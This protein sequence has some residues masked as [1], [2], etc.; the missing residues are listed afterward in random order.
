MTCESRRRRGDLNPFLAVDPEICYFSAMSRAVQRGKTC[1]VYGLA[2]FILVAWSAHGYAATEISKVR[3]WA[4]PDHTRVVFD[5]SAEPDYQF[6]LRDN[7]LTLEFRGASLHPSLSGEKMV[8]KPGISKII[9]STAD[10]HTCKIEIVLTEYLTTEVFKLRQIL[11]KPDRIVVD[12]IVEPAAK[13]EAV[14][15]RIVPSV[16][17]RVI[18]IDPGHGGEDPGAV[19][20]N[21]TYEKHVV[22]AMGR[23]IKK[24]IDAMPGYSAVLTRDGD[25]YV[26]FSKRLNT[27]RLSNASLFISVHADAARNRQARGSSVYCLSTGAASNEAA[28]LLANNENLSDIV[29]GV[30]NGEGNNQSDEIILN[31]FQTNTINLSK[32]FA[33]DLL[34]QL[35]R[36]QH[37]KYPVFHEAPFR[38][39]KLLDT[40]AVLLETAFISH[41]GEERLLMKSSFRKTIAQAVAASVARYFSGTAVAASSPDAAQPENNDA[42]VVRKAPDSG[43]TATYRVRRGDTLNAVARRHETTLAV[44]L[45]LN[46]LKIN[47]PL[48]VGRK[49]LVPVAEPEPAAALKIYTV[50]KGDTLF[51][52]AKSCKMTVAELRRI[53]KMTD[54]DVLCLGQKIKLPE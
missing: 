23:E 15:E 8:G 44:L 34:D 14:R 28:K 42:P 52:L 17:R 43:K 24:A 38:V 45:K 32:T 53:N 40:P 25:Y 22:L 16:K 36:V 31:M 11:D 2:I 6:Y 19:G 9:F 13:I 46:H 39:L 5:L 29:G 20:K 37:L 1:I 27:A 4:A 47:D 21:G 12:I 18:V 26:S 49:I 3:H 35:G 10:N 48:Y 7:V 33:A 41:A 54:A 30:P 50:K 51:S